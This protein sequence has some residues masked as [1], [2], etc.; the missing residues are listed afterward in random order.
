MKYLVGFIGICFLPF[1][2]IFVAFEAACI[3]VTNSCNEDE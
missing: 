1:A 3:Y 2:V